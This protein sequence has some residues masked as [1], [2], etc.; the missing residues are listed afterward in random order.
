MSDVSIRQATAA[1]LP[2]VGELTFAAYTFDYPELPAD[3][4]LS[5]R[6][7]EELL[8]EYDI[9]IAEDDS[10]FVGVVSVRHAPG[11]PG[12]IED[13]ELYFRLLAVSPDARRRGIAQALIAH[14]FT[15]AAAAGKVRVSMNSGPEMLGAHA[16]YRRLGFIEP[17]GRQ[18]DITE[19][20]GHVFHLHTF[21]RDVET[22]PLPS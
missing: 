13:D 20:D 9:W 19:D 18:H 21:V 22:E 3:Y 2:A 6:H 17:P 7:P 11:Q 12:W 4:Q 14:V 8:A 16:L 1:D 10:G 15:L 5:L